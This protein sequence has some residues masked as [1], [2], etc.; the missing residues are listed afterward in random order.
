MMT[1]RQPPLW[2]K[3]RQA[4]QDEEDLVSDTAVAL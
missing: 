4:H 1:A 2:A 3:A